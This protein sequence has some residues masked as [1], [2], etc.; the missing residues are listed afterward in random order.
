MLNINDPNIKLACLEH[1]KF[2]C[3]DDPSK[4]I[5]MAKKIFAWVTQYPYEIEPTEAQ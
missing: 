2:L 5:E 1:A 4:L 3:Q